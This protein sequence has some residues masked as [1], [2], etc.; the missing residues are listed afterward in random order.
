MRQLVEIYHWAYNNDLVTF[1]EKL[2][3][4]EITADLVAD[5][6]MGI[7]EF[8]KANFKGSTSSYNA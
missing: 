2:L 7:D 6:P 1:R 3:E 4:Q 8:N 5:K